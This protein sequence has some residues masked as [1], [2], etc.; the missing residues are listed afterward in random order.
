M[1]DFPKLI[2]L[3]AAMRLLSEAGIDV[4]KEYLR[5]EVARGNLAARKIGRFWLIS[6]SD[7]ISF[8]TPVLTDTEVPRR[9]RGTQPA[10]GAQEDEQVDYVGMLD[11]MTRANKAKAKKAK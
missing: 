4:S 9:G 3:Q 5:R 2:T 1:A 7:L 10:Q 11:A 8:V 6:E